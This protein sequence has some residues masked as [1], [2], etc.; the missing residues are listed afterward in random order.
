MS[1][2]SETR[3]AST[4]KPVCHCHGELEHLALPV[5]SVT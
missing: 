5:D 4:D 2:E 1:K 3:E